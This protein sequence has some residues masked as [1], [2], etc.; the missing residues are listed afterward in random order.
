MAPVVVALMIVLF[1]LAYS[2]V[3]FLCRTASQADGELHA[4]LDA[5]PP[6]VAEEAPPARLAV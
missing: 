2:F 3:W 6:V 1:S 4:L 5:R